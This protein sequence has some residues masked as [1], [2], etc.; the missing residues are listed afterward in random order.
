M[1]S[2]AAIHTSHVT[3]SSPSSL[4]KPEPGARQPPEHERGQRHGRQADDLDEHEEP[5]LEQ[6]RASRP[7]RVP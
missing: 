4:A 2:D 3:S 1:P 6:Q 7:G 5:A